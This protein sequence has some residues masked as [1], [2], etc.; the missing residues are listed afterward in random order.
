MNMLVMKSSINGDD[1]GKKFT[2]IEPFSQFR[3][4]Q[5]GALLNDK[6]V[7]NNFSS[8]TFMKYRCEF[9]EVSAIKINNCFISK[10]YIVHDKNF[11]YVDSSIFCAPALDRGDINSP[12]ISS[13]VSSAPK[14]FVSDDSYS[15]EEVM[16]FHNE[17][18]GTWGHFLAQNIPRALLLRQRFPH[19]KI[20]IPAGHHPNVKN[21]FSKALGIF[22]IKEDDIVSLDSKKTYRFQSI[23]IVNF[24]YSWKSGTHIHPRAIQILQDHYHQEYHDSHEEKIDSHFFVERS[25]TSRNINNLIDVRNV[26]DRFYIE[27]QILGKSP[28]GK[29]FSLWSRAR[30]AC[31]I[32]GSDLTNMIFSREGSSILA[33]SPHDFGDSFFYDLAAAKNL[34]WFEIRCGHVTDPTSPKHSTFSVDTDL[35][36]SALESI[37]RQ[38]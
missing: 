16:V 32:L 14:Y 22:G 9:K 25:G 17:G 3:T 35:L 33:I 36:D 20:A 18:G 28:P 21:N 12:Q 30:L 29:Q 34:R 1:Y 13:T 2:L 26:F 38:T 5:L 15:H 31:G 19:V 6:Y 23:W 11:V 8:R 4:P 27:S 24:L 10:E 7:K 37:T